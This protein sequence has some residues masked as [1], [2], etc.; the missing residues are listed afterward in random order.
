MNERTGHILIVDDDEDILTAGRLLLRRNFGGVTTCRDPEDIPELLAAN[1]FDAE[2]VVYGEGCAEL[3]GKGGP[4]QISLRRPVN[5]EE[6]RRV[7]RGG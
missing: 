4:T 7:L 1:D 2:T 6:L 3:A 5:M